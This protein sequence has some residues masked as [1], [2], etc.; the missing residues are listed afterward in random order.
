MARTSQPKYENRRTRSFNLDQP[1][2][3]ELKR[4]AA[5]EGLSMSDI[6]NRTLIHGFQRVKVAQDVKDG[7]QTTLEVHV[8][9]VEVR[10]MRK[11]G[12]GADENK[13]NPRHIEGKCKICWPVIE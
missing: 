5:L 12:Q 9:T 7:F 13:C 4:L 1:H 8:Q 11:T 2:Y 6:L 10:M 3:L